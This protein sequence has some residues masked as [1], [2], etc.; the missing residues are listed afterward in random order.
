MQQRHKKAPYKTPLTEPSG[1]NFFRVKAQKGEVAGGGSNIIILKRTLKNIG[2]ELK[3]KFTKHF[4]EVVLPKRPYL[5][6]ELIEYNIANP[7]KREFQ[8][9]NKI[10]LWGY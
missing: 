3:M 1:R 4:I 5:D 8:E 7:I 2:S 6:K 10:K 9:D